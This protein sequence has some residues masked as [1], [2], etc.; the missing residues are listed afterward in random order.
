MPNQ[1][2][3][4]LFEVDLSTV[5]G[6]LFVNQVELFYVGRLKHFYVRYGRVLNL[7]FQQKP[8]VQL[9]R[10]AHLTKHAACMKYKEPKFQ[11]RCI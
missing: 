3:R 8:A 5:C 6:V 11:L 1:V 10:R 4:S 2:L 9:C 7:D